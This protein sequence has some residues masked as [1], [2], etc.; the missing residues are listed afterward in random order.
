MEKE[1]KNKS[2]TVC[3]RKDRKAVKLHEIYEGVQFV[4]SCRLLNALLD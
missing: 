1:K 3:L 2:P 4:T